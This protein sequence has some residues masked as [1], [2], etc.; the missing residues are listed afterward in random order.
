MGFK[1]EFSKAII[2]A[3]G[4]NIILSFI[5]VYFFKDIGASLSLVGSEFV[6]LIVLL[7]FIKEKNE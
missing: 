3:G 2:I 6:L 5:L 4:S 7:K 1:K